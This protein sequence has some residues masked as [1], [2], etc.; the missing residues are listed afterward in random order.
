MCNHYR[1]SSDVRELSR[2]IVP[3][4]TIPEPLPDL[5]E[6]SWPRKPAPVVI[7][8]AGARTLVARRGGVWPFSARAKSEFLMC[9]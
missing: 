3:A 4:L 5:P 7:Q 6:H 9:P 1:K 8:T 2:R